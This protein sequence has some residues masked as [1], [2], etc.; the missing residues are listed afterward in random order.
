MNNAAARILDNASKL[1]HQSQTAAFAISLVAKVAAHSLC[2]WCAKSVEGE[3]V[4]LPKGGECSNCPYVGHD[5]L[6]IVE[7]AG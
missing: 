7:V 4:R 6:V 1:G 2:C 3:A 5:C